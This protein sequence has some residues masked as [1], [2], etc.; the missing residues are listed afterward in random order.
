MPSK[1]VTPAEQPEPSA[2][3]PTTRQVNVTLDPTDDSPGVSLEVAVFT[4]AL[5]DFELLGDLAR[6]DAG[7]Q[8]LMPQILGRLVSAS[9]YAR[10]LDALRNE[11]T[12]RVPAA[13]GIRF[14]YALLNAASPNS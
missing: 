11:V 9:E 14:V 5:D 3:E 6:L 4:D 10:I 8:S 7:N 12:G 1:T 13:R 2:V